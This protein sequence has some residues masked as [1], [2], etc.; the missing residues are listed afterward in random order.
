M[1]ARVSIG[2][3]YEGQYPVDMFYVEDNYGGTVG[4]SSQ[5]ISYELSPSIGVSLHAT[6]SINS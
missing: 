3:L 5:E 6:V 1:V 4:I 2:S